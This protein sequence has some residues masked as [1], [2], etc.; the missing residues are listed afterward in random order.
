M[1]YTVH[2]YF[3]YLMFTSSPLFACIA[4]GRSSEKL[5]SHLD[6]SLL[7]GHRLIPLIGSPPGSAEYLE[8]KKWH[9]ID[10]NLLLR[11][12]DTQALTELNPSKKL[13]QKYVVFKTLDALHACCTNSRRA[14]AVSHTSD[15]AKP[16]HELGA[17]L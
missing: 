14:K 12:T 15:A 4:N 9:E 11:F 1:Y 8:Q 7:Q 5:N 10:G 3:I 13:H 17:L 16:L 2:V 6:R